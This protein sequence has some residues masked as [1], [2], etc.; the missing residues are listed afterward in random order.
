[1]EVTSPSSCRKR[2]R[3]RTFNAAGRTYKDTAY[4]PQFALG[5]MCKDEAH[6]VNLHARLSRR[7]PGLDLRV[8]V[9]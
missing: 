5:I 9:I 8:L 4:R 3:R 7:F 2:T 6:Q 1:M